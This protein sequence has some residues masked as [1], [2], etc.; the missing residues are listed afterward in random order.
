[1]EA[2]KKNMQ[3]HW[4]MYEFIENNVGNYEEKGQ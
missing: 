4:G 3:R 2:R 1:M